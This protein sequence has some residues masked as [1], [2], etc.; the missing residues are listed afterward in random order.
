MIPLEFIMLWI[1]WKCVLKLFNNRRY[2]YMC[3][4]ESVPY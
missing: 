4:A 3:F 1:G 2:Y